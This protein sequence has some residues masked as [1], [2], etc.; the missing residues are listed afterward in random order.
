VIV[1]DGS[2]VEMSELLAR[3]GDSSISISDYRAMELVPQAL[4][5]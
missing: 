5:G 1:P 4:A 3:A 2:F